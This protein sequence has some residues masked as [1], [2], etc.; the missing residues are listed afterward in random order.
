MAGGTKDR[1]HRWSGGTIYGTVFGLAGPFTARTIYRVTVLNAVSIVIF[2][3]ALFQFGH[4]TLA[5]F[6]YGVCVSLVCV[7]FFFYKHWFHFSCKF[8]TG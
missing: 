6:I 3:T 1:S 4:F 5:H 2:A 7:F 8:E